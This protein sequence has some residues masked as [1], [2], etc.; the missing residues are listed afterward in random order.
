MNNS[1]DPDISEML[2]IN[3]AQ[4]AYYDAPAQHRNLV[5]RL[6]AH[7]RNRANQFRRLSGIRDACTDRERE[8]LGDLTGKSVL[9]LGCGTGNRLSLEI[10]QACA[11]YLAIDL[12]AH[13]ISAFR[14]KLD[15]E[16]L[17]HARAEVIDFLSPDFAERFDVIYAYG[18]LHHFAHFD[19]FLAV[20]S[21]HL[22]PGGRI[23][24]YD[25]LNISPIIRLIRALYRPFQSDRE[26]EFPFTE[27]SLRAIER[28][29]TIRQAQGFLGRTKWALPVYFIY[30]RAGVALGK[31]FLKRDLAHAKDI[32]HI[33]ACLHVALWL[34]RR[35]RD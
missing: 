18:V 30:P 4:S 12:S 14:A 21:D 26:W 23:V 2:N 31:R 16:H 11:S 6:W 20:L 19:E 24:S 7:L 3:R 5:S 15:A 28:H 35:L 32:D 10:A 22:N 33:R 1:P 25:P 9:D 13:S 29:F 8:W 17:P 34:E 27:A